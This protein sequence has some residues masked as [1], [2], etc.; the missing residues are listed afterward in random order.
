M[1][2]VRL[3]VLLTIIGRFRIDTSFVLT[4]NGPKS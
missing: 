4:Q 1:V 2:K 3:W